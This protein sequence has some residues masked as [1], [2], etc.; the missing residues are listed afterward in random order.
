MTKATKILIIVIIWVVGMLIAMAM[1]EATGT[2]KGGG[3][4]MAVMIGV[5]AATA[6][7]WKWKPDSQKDNSSKL[8]KK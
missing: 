2:K 7:I 3:L 6:A 4:G 8:N 5:F 1:G